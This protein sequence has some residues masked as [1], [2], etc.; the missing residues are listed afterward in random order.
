MPA[1]FNGSATTATALT[2]NS[3]VDPL[4]SGYHWSFN[5]VQYSFITPASIFSNSYPNGA[6]LTGGAQALSAVQ[7]Q[8]FA[9]VAKTISN[10]AN[11]SIVPTGESTTFVGDVRV[12]FSTSYN[13]LNGNSGFAYYA[14]GSP[15]GGDIWLNPAAKDLVDGK[16]SGTLGISTFA[17][18]S[19]AM[20]TLVYQALAALGLKNATQVLDTNTAVLDAAHNGL[21]YTLMGD[22]F[23]AGHPEMI[24]LN[25]YP[26]TPMVLD[27][28]ALQ[29]MYGANKTYNAGDTVYSFNDNPGQFYNQTLWDAGGRNTIAYS[30]DTY[31]IIDLR[32]GE[33]SLIGNDV[34]AYGNG[35]SLSIPNVWIAYGTHINTAVV[36]GSADVDFIAND[37]GNTLTGGAGDD[38]FFGGAGNDVM[39]G[40][41]GIDYLDGGAG[42]DT[43]V[44]SNKLISYLVKVGGGPEGTTSVNDVRGGASGDAN[45]LLDNV[46]RLRFADTS[47]ALDL[48]TTQAGGKAL[49]TLGAALGAGVTRDA[50]LAGLF[51]G[52]YDSGA[53]VLQGAQLL[54]DAGIMA[55]FAGGADNA[56]LARFVYTNV[57]G[58]APDAATLAALV[59]PLNAHTTTQA[60]WL[61]DMALSITNQQHVGL[62]GLAASGWQ[63][64][65]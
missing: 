1:P 36:T 38:N 46:E 29:A 33:G 55:A 21:D 22:L 43:A 52:F 41:G 44:F 54:V 32:Q 65:P 58:Q 48:G 13:W 61:A 49:L 40:N 28:A 31:S 7:Q 39:R 14:S 57:N 56:A 37:E 12:G 27:V 20:Q 64:T 63:Y 34:Y 16:F 59:A 60:Q 10:Y 5:Y 47:L 42:T 11:V 2:G 45:D 3:L 6:A 25:Y 23:L 9:A 15:A 18:G 53:S 8:V 26:T 50:G 4:F 35:T 62:A 30:G 19:Y 24:G 51:L 17:P